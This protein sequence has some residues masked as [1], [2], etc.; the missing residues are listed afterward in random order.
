MKI[1]NDYVDSEWIKEFDDVDGKYVDQRPITQY[2][3]GNMVVS[4]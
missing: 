1:E 3:N 4:I 2:G